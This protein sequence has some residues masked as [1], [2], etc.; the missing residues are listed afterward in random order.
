M[1]TILSTKEHKR[2]QVLLHDPTSFKETGNSAPRR[3]RVAAYA[4]VSTEL[5]SQQNSYEAQIDY[6]TTYIQNKPEWEFVRVYADE[7]ITGT[8]YKRRDGFNQMI[9]DAENGKIDLILTKSISRFARNTVD[10]LTVTRQLKADN[11]EVFFEKE[12]ISSM[13]AQAELIFTIMSSIAQEESRSISQNVRWGLLRSM[14]AGKISLPWKSFL[15]F[16]KGPDGLPQIVEEEAEI[17]RKIYRD[18]LDGKT[19]QGIARSL[20][21]NNIKT[22]CGK[23]RWTAEAVRHILTNE[24]YK[25]D[26]ILQKT[27]TVDFLSKEVRVNNGERKQWYIRDSHDAIVTPEAY[28]LVQAELKRRGGSR[29]RY[30]DSPFTGNLYCGVC[31]NFC[32]HHTRYIAA[33]TIDERTGATFYERAGHGKSVWICNHSNK[34]GDAEEMKAVVPCQGCGGMHKGVCGA[35]GVCKTPMVEDKKIR[36]AFLV[37]VNRVLCGYAINWQELEREILNATDTQAT[38]A[39]QKIHDLLLSLLKEHK[40]ITRFD[41]HAWHTLVD[42]AEI[43]ANDSLIFHFRD[44]RKEEVS[45][46]EI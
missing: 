24:K 34:H 7:G 3:K 4:R 37:A 30:F 40:I 45:L 43:T 15:G 12:N 42:Y 36:K 18:Y 29:G 17:I 14:E 25:G 23:E 28:K 22:A 33:K 21:S 38:N 9:V 2:K 5:D 11:I 19:L 20:I 44:G 46:K 13:D 35:S 10:A 8:S 16:E 1:T 31:G 27:Y 41:E 39:E 26:A 32:G 6:Y